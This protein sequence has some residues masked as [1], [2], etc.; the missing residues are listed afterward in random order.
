MAGAR[1]HPPRAIRP[2]TASLDDRKER[3]LVMRR[4]ANIAGG[5]IHL[6][7]AIGMRSSAAISY[8]LTEERP[9]PQHWLDACQTLIEEHEG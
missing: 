3:A 2:T 4:A 8:Y 6:A 5:N 9:I 7:R 1:N